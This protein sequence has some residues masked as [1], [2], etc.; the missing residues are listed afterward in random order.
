MSI[1]R[2]A[3]RVI[4]ALFITGHLAGCGRDTDPLTGYVEGEFVYVSS[5]VSGK[6]TALHVARGAQAKQGALLFEIEDVATRAERDAAEARLAQAQAMLRDARKGQRPT[7]LDALQAQH[8][9]AIAAQKLA[10]VELARQQKLLTS[11][12][13]GSEQSVDVAR[14][15]RDQASEQVA[16]LAAQLK[17][18]RLGARADQVS[19]AQASV[20]AAQ[21]QLVQAEWL[22]GQTRQSALTEGIVADTLY[23]PGEFVTAGRPVVVILPPANIKVRT[24]VPESLLAKVQLGREATIHIDG[25]S[26]PIA[27]RISFIAPRMEF[28]PPVIY[29]QSTRSKF[30]ALVEISIAPEIATELHPGQPLDVSFPP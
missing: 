26:D 30:V 12:V 21:A 23:R 27:G 29:S 25:R 19:A 8:Q 24:Y 9:Q 20:D 5:P 16:T 11:G 18:A 10:E 17:T 2:T 1:A 3:Q 7:E 14:A 6:L 22:L 28:T 15:T 4:L 13:G